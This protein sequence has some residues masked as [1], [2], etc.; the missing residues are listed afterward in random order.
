MTGATTEQQRIGSLD[1]LRGF[2]LLGILLLNI[3]GFGLI[4]SAYFNP[5]VGSEPHITANLVVWG[6][7]DLLFE[8]AMRGLFSILFGAGVVLFNDAARGRTAGLHYARMFWLLI[9]G[10]AD[11]FLLLWVGDIL[12]TYAVAGMLLYPA[13][14]ASP[15]RLLGC[16]GVLLLILTA[17]TAGTGFGLNL[18]YHASQTGDPTELVQTWQEFEAGFNQSQESINAELAA[19]R[20]SLSSAFAFNLQ[21]SL[22]TLLFVVPVYMLWDALLM[23]LIGMALM[24]MRILDASR[25]TTF[26]ARMMLIGFAVGLCVNAMEVHKVIAGG[27]HILDTFGYAQWS[28]H[29]GR[30]A[31]SFGYLGLLLYIC[32][33][34]VWEGFRR[35]LAA[36]GRMA[37]TNYLMQS[38]IGMLLFSGAGLALVG[39]FQ[40]WELLLVVAAI[41]ALQIGYSTWWLERYQ[42]GPAE[43]FWRKLTYGRSRLRRSP[44]T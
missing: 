24:K 1:E 4:S 43:W 28:Y 26:Y 7:V 5:L 2:A 23:M 40:R 18:A 33:M 6:S 17:M 36:I 15:S 44:A 12:L 27:F 3:L 13:R 34:G 16:A 30:G 29:L 9:F 14:N 20:G 37:L 19:R 38:L 21:Q 42:Q 10:L 32:R 39:K 41:W 22:N 31:V 8:G 25:S 11:M 35:R